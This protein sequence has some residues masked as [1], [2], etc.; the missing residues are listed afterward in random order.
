M[1][2]GMVVAIIGSAAGVAGVL[3]AVLQL[4]QGR[5]RKPGELPVSAHGAASAAGILLPP[6]GLLPDLVCGRDDVVETLTVAAAAPDGKVHVLVGLG[7]CG[8]STVALALARQCAEAGQQV[9][10]LPV[11]DRSSVTSMLLGLARLLGASDG[12]VSE[13][14][15]GRISPSGVL[16]RRLESAHGWVLILDN[17]DDPGILATAEH[18]AR[19]GAGWLRSTKAGL[20]LV[21][22]RTGDARAWGRL[23]TLHPVDALSTGDGARV[24]HGLAPDAGNDADARKLAARLAGLP[25]ALHQAGV[26]LSS[27]F[28]AERGFDAYGRAL[29]TRFAEL[30]GRGD[31]DRGRV[32]GTWEL[33]LAALAAQG[34]PQARGLLQVLSCFAAADPIPP[35]LLDLG[36]LGKRMGGQ[37]A[38][39]DGLEGLLSFQLITT[40]A[41][42]P[43][44]TRPLVQVHP[45]VAETVRHQ[46]GQALADSYCTAVDLLREAVTRLGVQVPKD[47]PKWLALLPHLQAL[48]GQEATAPAAALEDLAQ[49]AHVM[50]EALRWGGSYLASL[51]VAD[52]ALQ[53]TVTLGTSNRQVLALRYSRAFANDMLC[54]WAEA[55]AE[56]RDVRDI[57][58]QTLGPEHPDTLRTRHLLADVLVYLN[59]PAEAAGE[60]KEVLTA[61][62][63]VLGPEHPDTIN[64]W[65]NV[66]W[67]L[68]VQ[69]RN[70]DA[71]AEFRQIL[72]IQVRNLGT[73]HR[74]TLHMRDHTARTLT[75]Q[76]KAAEAEAMFR[77][78]LAIQLRLLGPEHPDTATSR[79]GIGDALAAQGKPADAEAELRR[80][81]QTRVRVL[82]P[83]H[84]DTL[85]TRHSI[86]C[87]LRDQG[88]S[89]DAI[90]ELREVLT[91]RTQTLGAEHVDTL[92]TVQALKMTQSSRPPDLPPHGLP[93]EA[94]VAT[95]SPSSRN[96]AQ[97]PGPPSTLVFS[98][99]IGAC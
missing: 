46:A 73:E 83:S 12:E 5:R 28:T 38:V 32:T 81:L 66:A 29:E 26:Y 13:A 76:G 31:D 80:A 99:L 82:G 62:R 21:T 63:T 59:R 91:M 89:T 56:A 95:A 58:S 33:S 44:K 43:G 41:G 61:R 35:L 84:P 15:A 16:W 75:P 36:L 42:E 1:D 69:N 48:A 6:T 11:V 60:F 8:K 96:T 77:Q 97:S 9:W 22:S 70:A 30:L 57:Q 45:L 68:A 85:T 18:P 78:S 55:E 90:T 74:E 54:S 49:S 92:R 50:S 23:A 4:R 27:D 47:Q 64:T 94:A 98:R 25:L 79:H 17:A 39:E 14:L 51:E 20:V 53:R 65:H 19:A 10:W 71:E 24:L 87:A 86:G 7:G 52:R 34:K 40:R 2:V 88:K 3:V 93:H 72:A 67:V 37:R